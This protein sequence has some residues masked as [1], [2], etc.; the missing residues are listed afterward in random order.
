MPFEPDPV[1][2]Y[3]AAINFMVIGRVDNA[4]ASLGNARTHLL[5]APYVAN[6]APLFQPYAASFRADPR[7]MVLA[8]KLG[9]VA[10][11]QK[12]KWPDFCN[13]SDAPYNCRTVAQNLARQRVT[14]LTQRLA[15]TK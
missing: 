10:I 8:A 2:P 9:L 4:Y 15:K 14:A 6:T 7:F 3:D 11:W 1:L 12:T 5:I 13:A